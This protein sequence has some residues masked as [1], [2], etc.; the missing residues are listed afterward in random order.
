VAAVELRERLVKMVVQAVVEAAV[1]LRVVV[2]TPH[3]QAHLKVI[4][5]AQVL[6]FPAQTPAAAEVVG[7]QLAL[8]LHQ[9]ALALVEQAYQMHIVVHLLLMLVAVAAALKVYP[10]EQ[11]VAVA[12]VLVV[13][14]TRGRVPLDHRT[15]EA[16]VVALVVAVALEQAVL[17]L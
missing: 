5:A 13:L 1:L 11:V 15:L 4:T 6:R 2:E 7:A 12:V 14:V 8:M 17:A 16:V 10:V 9:V 3:Q